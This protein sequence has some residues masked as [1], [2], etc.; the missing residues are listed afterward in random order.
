ML[1]RLQ[2]QLLTPLIFGLGELV[3]LKISYNLINFMSKHCVSEY[4]DQH[5]VATNKSHSSRQLGDG[6]YETVYHDKKEFLP[7]FIVVADFISNE[8][9][10]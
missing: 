5:Q 4:Q 3:E 1:L 8:S 9:V 6:G 2:K 10:G 7:L